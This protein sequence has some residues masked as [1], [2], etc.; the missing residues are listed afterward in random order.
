M[1]RVLVAALLLSAGCSAAWQRRKQEVYGPINELLHQRFPEALGAMDRRRLAVLHAPGGPAVSPATAKLLDR[2]RR[3]DVSQCIIEQLDIEGA[4]RIVARCDVRL[5]GTDTHGALLGV[6]QTRRITL[7]RRG[8]RWLIARDVVVASKETRAERPHFREESIERGLV[9]VHRPRLVPDRKGTMRRFFPGSGIAAGDVD[10]DGWTDLVVTD[11]SRIHLYRNRRGRFVED[12]TVAGLGFEVKGVVTCLILGDVDNDGRPDLFAGVVHGQPLLLRNLGGRFVKVEN[13]GIRTAGMVMGACLADF[14]GDGRL[15]LFLASNQDLLRYRPEPMGY[16][17][18]GVA[19]QLYRNLGG[20]R[21]TD[22]TRRA[23]VGDTGW[24][25]AC[26][27]ADFDGDG[28]I[29]LFVGNDFGFDILYRNR[30]D[31]TFEDVT[32]R[33]GVDRPAA[34]MSAAWGDFHGEGRLDLFVAGMASDFAW[35]LDAR[36]FPSPAPWLVN[37]LFRSFVMKEFKS[38]FHGNRFYRN[39]GD[40]T[41]EEVSAASG[42]RNSGWGWSSVPLDYDNDGRLDV[43]C[44]NGFVSGPDRTDM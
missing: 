44:C 10:G 1:K 38:F 23:G 5:G 30:G 19:N 4:D 2:Y 43:Y 22:D 14:D 6:E 26:A 37:L 33:A 13:T 8:G 21:F 11:G 12:S 25:L 29:D 9:F 27:A 16:A 24:A 36:E 17:K 32:S 39:R 18:N 28:K 3:I 41:F 7:V 42:T 35:A 15:D 20:W 40:G 31:G 34:T